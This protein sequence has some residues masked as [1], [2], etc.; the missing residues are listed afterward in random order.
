MAQACPARLRPFGAEAA[1]L[2]VD[3]AAPAPHV[4]SA[5]LARCARDAAGAPL[6]DDAI[7]DLAVGARTEAIVALAAL[8]GAG[9]FTKP[10]RCPSAGCG[11][12]L[13]VEITSADI[14]GWGA[15]AGA[16]EV[17]VQVEGRMARLRRPTGRDQRT[18]LEAGWRDAATAR[19]AM[20]ATLV[21]EG[22]TRDPGDAA[23]S[24][25]EEAL[26][27]ID[28][29]VGFSL[30]VSCPAC[31]KSAPHRI[32]LERNALAALRAAQERLLDA[33]ARLARA[34][35][36]NEREILALP[37]WRRERYLDLAGQAR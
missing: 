36:W 35:H 37:R 5:L 7:W 8:S 30:E 2:D 31:G 21:T 26:A 19:R 1:D 10:L 13:E 9:A 24:V 11:E 25:M 17:T 12:A 33:V 29:L 20:L 28:P 14:A 4:V 18:W 6:A 3:F 15:E 32:D 27:R 22:S 23:V 34:F 16:D